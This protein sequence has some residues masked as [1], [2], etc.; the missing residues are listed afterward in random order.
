[1]TVFQFA[2]LVLLLLEALAIWLI[3]SFERLLEKYM[4]ADG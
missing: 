4:K 2:L 3:P 1:M